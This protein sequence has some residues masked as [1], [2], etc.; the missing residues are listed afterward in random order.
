M[1]PVAQRR[2]RLAKART[3]SVQ[4]KMP[5]KVQGE[6]DTGTVVEVGAQAKVGGAGQG[7]GA[8]RGKGTGRVTGDVPAAET[9]AAPEEESGE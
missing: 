1:E 7:R 6:D 4:R 5:V 9:A 3:L 8:G 2:A